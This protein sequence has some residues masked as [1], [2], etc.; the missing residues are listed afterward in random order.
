MIVPSRGRTGRAGCGPAIRGGIISPA[1]V[2]RIAYMRSTPHDHLTVG[3]YRRMTTPG[4]RR[5]SGA[6][7]GPA[8]GG[9][10]VFPTC[11]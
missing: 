9:G 10:I 2:Q 1:T 5:I 3:P 7:R 4:K 6:G 8:I 11:S